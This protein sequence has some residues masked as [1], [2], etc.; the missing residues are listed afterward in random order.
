MARVSVVFAVE[1]AAKAPALQA[2]LEGPRDFA[3][4]P[5]QIVQP[6]HGTVTWLVDDAASRDLHET[7]R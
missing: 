2:V 6:A 3:R 1:G 7:A 4:W 5:A